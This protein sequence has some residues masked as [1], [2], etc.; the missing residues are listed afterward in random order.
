MIPRS[1]FKVPN[2]ALDQAREC[3]LKMEGSLDQ[4]VTRY[5]LKLEMYL[6]IVCQIETQII[7]L[8]EDYG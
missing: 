6:P 5:Q 1:Y 4:E 2:L 8:Y 7:N 3:Q